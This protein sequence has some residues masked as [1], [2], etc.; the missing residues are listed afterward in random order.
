MIDTNQLDKMARPRFNPRKDLPLTSQTPTE[1]FGHD[2][3]NPANNIGTIQTGPMAGGNSGSRSQ[4]TQ[5]QGQANASYL[6][7]GPWNVFNKQNV[8]PTTVTGQRVN[9]QSTPQMNE[10]P[11]LG[12]G[13]NKNMMPVRP[14]AGA[15]DLGNQQSLTDAQQRLQAGGNIIASHPENAVAKATEER[16]AAQA[17]AQK[18]PQTWQEMRD[19]L[20]G[21]EADRLRD[22]KKRAMITAIGDSL[23]HIGN[24]G[25]T[26]GHASPQQYQTSP[27][28]AIS[29]DYKQGKKE[30]DATSYQ[31]YAQKQKEKIAEFDRQMKLG[32]LAEKQRLNDSTIEKNHA[33]TQKTLVDMK[34]NAEKYPWEIKELMA[35]A[36]KTG[37]EADMAEVKAA[38]EREYG[39]KE[40]EAKIGEIK[41]ATAHHYAS[42]ESARKS[43]DAAIMNAQT[44]AKRNS[45]LNKKTEAEIR[46][47]ESGKKD[48][49]RM[50]TGDANTM[51]EVN[52]ND[53]TPL[54]NKMRGIA[55]RKGKDWLGDN[56]DGKAFENMSSSDLLILAYDHLDDPEVAKALKSYGKLVPSN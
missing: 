7:R 55:Q 37:A 25:F 30:R 21:S 2:A 13:I 49:V 56:Y 36:A 5:Q 20:Y 42:A 14:M 38:I 34:I 22:A 16:A 19:Y 6:D 23:R 15:V 11:V 27:A 46:E 54:G 26:I 28:M 40:A 18:E 4:N 52:K 41:A 35:K 51:L 43:G 31:M 47:L 29:E 1:V 8:K 32:E 48:K 12:E 17:E 3:V 44:N 39:P 9:V 24:L 50:P 53:M 33:T 45:V 10:A